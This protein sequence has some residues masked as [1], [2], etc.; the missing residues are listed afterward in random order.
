[1]CLG[2][3]VTRL[4]SWFCHIFCKVAGLLLPLTSCDPRNRK[5]KLWWPLCWP[6]GWVGFNLL[7]FYHKTQK[8]KKKSDILNVA[9]II[10][11]SPVFPFFLLFIFLPYFFLP[12]ISLSL[13]H[14][15][16]FLVPSLVIFP[17]FLF[18]TSFLLCFLHYLDAC[19]VCFLLSFLTWKEGSNL[20][21]SFWLATFL[22]SF[23]SCWLT[24]FLFS[25]GF[26]PSSSS[27]LHYLFL[28][29]H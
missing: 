13:H 22:T 10:R 16:F 29:L 18:F 28:S 8:G 15:S 7:F 17:S 19:F 20:L 14:F 2:W 1:M 26:L 9:S 4:L 11:L 6:Q 23:F 24:C 5:S 3:G 21:F 25:S 27:S 12:L